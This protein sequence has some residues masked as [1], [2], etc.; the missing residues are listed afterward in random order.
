MTH[1][2]QLVCFL[3]HAAA[4]SLRGAGRRDLYA[5]SGQTLQGS[6]SDVSKPNFA[7]TSD[8]LRRVVQKCQTN[9]EQYLIGVTKRCGI[10][11][12]LEDFIGRHNYI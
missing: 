1:D 7:S 8:E 3:A 9:E 11:G 4:L 10:A 6:F 5:E 12:R 2:P